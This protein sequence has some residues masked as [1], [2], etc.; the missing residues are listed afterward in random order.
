MI[1]T[2]KKKPPQILQTRITDLVLRE[3]EIKD[4]RRKIRAL[5]SEIST[6]R[7]TIFSDLEAGFQAEPGRYTISVEARDGQSRPPWKDL[8]LDHFVS[9]HDI[10]KKQAE[11]DAREAYPGEVDKVLVIGV[12]VERA[13]SS[14]LTHPGL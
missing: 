12:S 5:E 14:R 9:A 6:A 3:E 13:P 11:N 4:L 2:K 7:L 8:Y 1:P 10:S